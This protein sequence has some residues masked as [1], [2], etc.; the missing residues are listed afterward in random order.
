MSSRLFAR[1]LAGALIAAGLWTGGCQSSPQTPGGGNVAQPKALPPIKS[2]ID[3]QNERVRGLDSLW[4]RVSLRVD[5]RLANATLNKEEAEGYLQVIF[6]TKVAVII[7]KLGN[8]YF[9]LGSNEEL[10][11][12][13]DLTGDKVA[14]FGRHAK[15]TPETVDRF[16]IPVHPLDLIELMAITPIPLPGQPGSPEKLH[17]STDRTLLWYDLPA[18]GSTKRVLVDPQSML[19]VMVELLDG[20]DKVVVRSELSKYV[21]FQSRSVV[22]ATPSLPSRCI[23][24]VPRQDLT[25]TINLNDPGNGTAGGKPINPAAFDFIKL[26]KESY[27]VP[28]LI[29]LDK[30]ETMDGA[31][32]PTAPDGASK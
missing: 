27:R 1:V 17:W 32:P 5:G 9:Y 4:A 31:E 25:I 29:D 30:R 24:K 8:T 7:N 23:I 21:A 6:P 14:F 28:R 22:G 26:L 12:W 10:Y 15:A 18:R 20:S 2:V 19:P 11:W 13:F 3:A 16:G